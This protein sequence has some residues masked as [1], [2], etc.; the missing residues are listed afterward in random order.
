MEATTMRRP[1][2]PPAPRLPAPPAAEDG[3]LRRAQAGDPAALALLIDEYRPR[4]Y[5]FALCQLRQRED[6]EDVTQ[7]TFMRMVRTIGSYSGRGVF[8]AWLYRI[9]VNACRDQQRRRSLERS[10]T[11]P[12]Q[13]APEAAAPGDV[14]EQVSRA[15]TL[16]A[17]ISRLPDKYREVV[18]LQWLEQLSHAEIG[19]ILG[20]PTNL[21]RVQ[22]WR[23]RGL[24]AR[25]LGDWLD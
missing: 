6:A 25:E 23:A 19:E 21:V 16:A 18:T 8:Q 22:L 9:A 15:L 20:R 17:A 5:S 10:R 13:E 2:D 14:Q 4:I 12:D 24:L 1:L 7:E 3:L 11:V